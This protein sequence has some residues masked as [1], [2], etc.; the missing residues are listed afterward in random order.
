MKAMAAL[1]AQQN[2]EFAGAKLQGNARH[3]RRDETLRGSLHRGKHQ[4]KTESATHKLDSKLT[5]IH[6]L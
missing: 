4:L 6:K 3:R 1:L 5:S 2:D